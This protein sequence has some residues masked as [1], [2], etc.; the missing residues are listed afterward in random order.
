MEKGVLHHQGREMA[1]LAKGRALFRLF[2]A[3]DTTN[4]YLSLTGKGKEKYGVL[5]L[6]LLYE[7][8]VFKACSCDAASISS[9]ALCSFL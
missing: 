5:L 8:V 4:S 6:S 7:F 1:G 2:F 3:W 9:V